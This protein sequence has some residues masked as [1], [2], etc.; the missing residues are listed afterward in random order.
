MFAFAED[1]GN[2][3]GTSKPVVFSIGHVRDPAIE[4]II[5]NDQI[6]QRS[7]YFLTAHATPSD[8]VRLCLCQ[9]TEVER[10]KFNHTDLVLLE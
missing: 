10:L 8:A 4:Y 5:A 1:L 9:G 2:V 6:Q 7:L 3:S